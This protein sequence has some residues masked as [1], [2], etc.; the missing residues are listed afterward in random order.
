MSHS[1]EMRTPFIDWFFFKKIVPLIKSDNKINK[2]SL[3]NC[4]K[5]NLPKN[6]EKRKKTGFSIPHKD[7]LTKLALKNK[8]ANPL[9]DW[10]IMSFEKYLKNDL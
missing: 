7:Y 8:Y 10:S 1:V 5:H 3:V 2:N 6:L 9:R 4:F